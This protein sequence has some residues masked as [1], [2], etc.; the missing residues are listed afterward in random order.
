MGFIAVETSVRTAQDAQ[1]MAFSHQIEGNTA[2]GGEGGGEDQ[3]RMNG[4]PAKNLPF[5]S[6]P[7]FHRHGKA[8]RVS[9][10]WKESLHFSQV[11]PLAVLV[12]APYFPRLPLLPPFPASTRIVAHGARQIASRQQPIQLEREILSECCHPLIVRLVTTF[13]ER[14]YE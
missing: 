3:R 13:Q 14:G 5:S 1:G 6:K 9:C 4:Y 2:K 7:R 8:F 10:C 12:L 11:V